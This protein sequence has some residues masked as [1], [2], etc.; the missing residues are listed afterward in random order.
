MEFFTFVY[1][2]VFIAQLIT[3]CVALIIVFYP[4]EKTVRSFL[5]A[6]A[7][8]VVLFGVSTLL[9]WGLFALSKSWHFLAGINFQLSWL[10]VIIA[11]LCI[12][13]IAPASRV[14]MGATLYVSVIAVADLGRQ[15]MNL[16]PEGYEWINLVFY[17]LIIAYSLLLRRYTLRYYSDIPAVS[18]ALI[19][20]NAVSSAVLIFAKTIINVY[21]G[22]SAAKDLYYTL[23]LCVIYI[24][25]VSGYLMIFFHCKVRKRMTELQVKNKLLESDKQM[26]VVSEQ[27][28]SEMR[29]MRHDIKNQCKVMEIMLAEGKYDELKKYFESMNESFY[30]ETGNSF[31]DCG[32]SLINSVINMEILKANKYGIQFVTTINVPGE[33]PFEQS[34]LCRILV[35]LIDN[36]LEAVLRADNKDFLV[37]CRIVCR[38]EQLYICVRNKL[39]E[40][41]DRDALLLMNT[42]KEDALN[43]GYG[44]RIIKRIAEK[45]NGI[46]NYTIEDNQFIAEVML[47][48]GI[49]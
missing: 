43:H 18:V 28:I 32:N 48:F 16:L 4:F 26:L 46:V 5:V 33:L 15:V 8:V 44:H 6:A 39:R 47:E 13:R 42:E 22:P 11:Y 1:D 30:S 27:A 2:Y 21:V 24:F 7:H 41:Y 40:G 49:I 35:N 19:M 25:A 20:L 14:I 34:D 45:Y 10:A 17:V 37:S 23:T 9:N 3:V 29:S 36:A 12:N 31:V 38:G